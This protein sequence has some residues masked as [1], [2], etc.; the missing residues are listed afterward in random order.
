MYEPQAPSW[1]VR[2]P[3]V[4]WV[5]PQFIFEKALESIESIENRGF[6]KVKVRLKKSLGK[7][8]R[9]QKE[10]VKWLFMFYMSPLEI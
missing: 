6:D 10:K 5:R 1:L 9:E 4:L 8:I 2:S 3:L 7:H